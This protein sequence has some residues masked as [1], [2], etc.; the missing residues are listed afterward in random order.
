[1]VLVLGGIILLEQELANYL[2][3]TKK[4][5]LEKQIVFPMVDSSL[6]LNVVCLDNISERLLIDINRKGTFKLTRCT[7]NERYQTVITL[8]RLDIDTKPHRNPDGT[9]I[10][11]NHIHIYK[12]GYG[13][14]WAYPLEDF[15][16]FKNPKDLIQ[17]FVDFCRFCNIVEIPTVQAV[18][19]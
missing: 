13:D 5:I 14:K 17:T 16:C 11:P 4:A 10:G 15:K 18:M 19:T 9:V 8:V 7:Y 3:Q 2:I 12:E 1:M 6:T